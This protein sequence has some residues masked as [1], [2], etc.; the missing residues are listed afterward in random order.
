M[1]E[2]QFDPKKTALV[3]IDLQNATVGM[4]PVPHTAAQVV[5]NSRKLAEAF[6]A[7]G[8]PVVY[9]RVDLNDFHQG[10]PSISRT[11]SATSR[12]PPAALVEIAPSAGFPARRY[13]PHQPSATG[14]AFAGTDLEQQL[15]TRGVDTVVLTGI[16]TNV[17]VE[18][19]ARQGAGLGFA[20]VL[21]E[22]ACS[23]QNAEHHRF[24]FENIFPRLARVRTTNEVLVSPCPR[25]SAN[26]KGST[27]WC[28][29]SHRSR[30]W[31]P[32]SR[33]SMRPS[34]TCRSPAS[35]RGSA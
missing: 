28:G 20:F 16:S 31:A 7:Q 11:T 4:N 10:F 23:A 24:A 5:E 12:Y 3:L 35:C 34:S 25:S 13:P 27:R 14:G 26:P 15:K 2:L 9:V 1:A 21:V 18:S 22:D 33:S 6:R 29:R 32:F 8:A 19:T 17:G 30:S